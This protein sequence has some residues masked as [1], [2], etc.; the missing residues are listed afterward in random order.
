LTEQKRIKEEMKEAYELMG[1]LESMIFAEM[2]IQCEINKNKQ[3]RISHS[4]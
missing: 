1:K 3:K 4:E 2:L